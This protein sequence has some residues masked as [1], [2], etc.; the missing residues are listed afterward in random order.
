[1]AAVVPVSTRALTQR[2]SAPLATPSDLSAK[3]TQAISGALNAAL[4]DVF[5]L[6]FK[7]KNF[8]W[9][10]GGPHFRDD[11]LMLDEQAAPLFAMTAPSAERCCKLGRPT[12]RF[13]GHIGR[14]HRVLDNDAEHVDPRDMLAERR[15]DNRDL[16]GQLRATH[17]L[18]QEHRDIASASLLEMWIGQI[19]QRSWFLFEAGRSG[20]TAGRTTPAT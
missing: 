18:S 7:S 11:H 20:E 12:L 15:E 10:M 19:E 1:M 6:Y 16:A 14:T 4:A 13:I 8:H 9:D 17:D 5:A 3:A 2:R